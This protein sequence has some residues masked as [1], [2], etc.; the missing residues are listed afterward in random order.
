MV[1]KQFAKL[2]PL[3]GLRVR[4]SHLPQLK[5]GDVCPHCKRGKLELVKE[6]Y[7]WTT[8]HLQCDSCDSTYNLFDTPESHSG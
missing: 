5:V 8:D 4:L 2:S 6:D 1:R 7:P 3:T